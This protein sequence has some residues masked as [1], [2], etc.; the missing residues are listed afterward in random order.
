MVRGKQWQQATARQEGARKRATGHHHPP[1]QCWRVSFGDSPPLRYRRRR[2]RRSRNRHATAVKT[3][4]KVRIL[5]AESRP[6]KK[7]ENGKI[8]SLIMAVVV[9]VVVSQKQV[10]VDRSCRLTGHGMTMSLPPPLTKTAIKVATTTTTKTCLTMATTTMKMKKG[11][12]ESTRRKRL[13]RTTR[14]LARWWTASLGAA[15]SPCCSN[16]CSTP[17]TWHLP[18]RRPRQPLPRPPCGGEAVRGGSPLPRLCSSSS[19]SSMPNT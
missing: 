14:L 11:L 16:T 17:P 1:S 6:P 3:A 15:R 8:K 9:V 2:R 4:G 18:P 13:Q 5:P 7:T 12:S 10:T 19:S